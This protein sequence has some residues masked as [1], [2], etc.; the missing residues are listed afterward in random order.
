MIDNIDN[1]NRAV[2]LRQND[3]NDSNWVKVIHGKTLPIQRFLNQ[4][5]TIDANLILGDNVYIDNGARIYVSTGIGHGARIGKDCFIGEWAGHNYSYDTVTIG[6][7]SKI[8]NYVEIGSN[9]KIG[10]RV[11]IGD[12]CTI[13]DCT[14]IGDD[15]EL[16]DGITLSKGSIVSACSILN[17]DHAVSEFG[18]ELNYV[19]GLRVCCNCLTYPIDF[20]IDNAEILTALTRPDFCDKNKIKISKKIKEIVTEI[21]SKI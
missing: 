16:T 12:N 21:R 8:G 6:A 7:N 17:T 18:I 13:N 2:F 1:G 14:V 9:V 19:G 10:K 20:W 15:A 5:I 4:S 11:K 3:S